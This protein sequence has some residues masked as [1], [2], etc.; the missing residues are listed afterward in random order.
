LAYTAIK[1]IS[2]PLGFYRQARWFH[3]HFLNR[4][5]LNQEK[6][7]LTFYSSYIHKSDLVFDVGAN[8]GDKTRVFLKLG[9]RV[10]AFEPQ[11]DCL[12]ELEA[13]CGRNRRL[14]TVQAAVGS[15]SGLAT[16]Y[17]R[18][19]RSV[20]GLIEDWEE[21]VESMI[22]VPT[23]TLDQMIAGHGKPQYLK[24]DVE[25]Y[26][27]EVLKGLTEP[28]PYIS[29]EY[30][31]KREDIEKTIKCITYLSR[32]GAISINITPAESLLFAYQEWLT[33][34]EFLEV[35]PDDISGKHAYRY[36]DIF[37]AI[38]VPDAGDSTI[39][40]RATRPALTR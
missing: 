24:I 10:V 35:F 20:S 38:D 34:D 33:N 21:D 11:A 26:E 27:Y 4:N 7:D 29:F 8:Y 15:V 22:V 6:A 3:R 36:G 1:K 2:R 18:A 25:G 31:L 9:A 17:V 40:R 30:H 32:L 37:V 12:E 13:R 14:T 16:F 5:E 23:V 28:V 39:G 19:R